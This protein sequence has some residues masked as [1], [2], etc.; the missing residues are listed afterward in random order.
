MSNDK[1]AAENALENPEQDDRR[2]LLRNLAKGGLFSAGALSA[3]QWTRPIVDATLVP[4]HAATSDEV[5]C[6]LSVNL[7]WATDQDCDLNL[8][9]DTP[10][11]TTI[12]PSNTAG[13]HLLHGGDM[14]PSVTN[15]T[16]ITE[17]PYSENISDIAGRLTTANGGIYSIYVSI[18][19]LGISQGTAFEDF[20]LR[21]RTCN[22]TETINGEILAP[23]ESRVLLATVNANDGSITV[24]T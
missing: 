11:G 9:I 23:D 4:V 7:D 13:E 21:I 20:Q 24:V 2:K 3:E 17:I 14:G 6:D 10:R 8:E 15:Q 16:T 22:D 18:D 1:I 12:S 19:D 5:V